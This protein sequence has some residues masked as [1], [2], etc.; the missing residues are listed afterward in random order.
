MEKHLG[1]K[2]F[3]K[4]SRKIVHLGCGV[5]HMCSFPRYLS[6]QRPNNIHLLSYQLFW[7]NWIYLLTFFILAPVKGELVLIY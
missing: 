4:T 2:M 7:S 1:K 3:E 5:K 6:Q